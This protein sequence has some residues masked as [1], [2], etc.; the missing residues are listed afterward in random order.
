MLSI[1]LIFLIIIGFVSFYIG[2]LKQSQITMLLSAICA[3]APIFYFV[4]LFA[5][6]PFVAPL[7]MIL[8][9]LGKKDQKLFK[10]TKR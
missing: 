5:F 6:L 4:G 2:Y 9:I 8:S 10:S 3:L 1:V 7:A